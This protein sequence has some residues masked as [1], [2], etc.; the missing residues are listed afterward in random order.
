MNGSYNAIKC[1]IS[2]CLEFLNRLL[3]EYSKKYWNYGFVGDFNV[4]TSDASMKEFCS[5]KRLKNLI[6]KPTCYKN[7]EK[8]TCIDL[9]ITNQPTLFQHSTVLETGL[10]DFH[11]LKNT[12]FKISFQKCTS[13]IITYWNYKNYAFRSEIQRFSLNKTDL[14][15]FNESI[16]FIFNKHASIRKIYIHLNETSFMNIKLHNAIIKRSRYR[17]KFLK[18][19][20]QTN[21]EN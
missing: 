5:L 17:N 8:P 10:S 21:R 15:L 1:Q 3:D 11:L 7:S 4:N 19:K 14:G 20:S 6:N 18:N 9:I 16:F 2:N 13:H 12:E